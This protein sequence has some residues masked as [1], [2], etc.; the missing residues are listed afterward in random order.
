MPPVTV[1]LD[2]YALLYTVDA[3]RLPQQTEIDALADLTDTYLDDFFSIVFESSS[4]AQFEGSTTLEDETIVRFGQP[5]QTSYFTDLTFSGSSQIPSDGELNGLLSSAFRGDNLAT[6]LAEVQ[7]LPRSNFFATTSAV[8][9]SD[10]ADTRS[11]GGSDL[12]SGVPAV[13]IAAAAGA[14]AFFVAVVGLMLYRRRDQD[15]DEAGKFLDGDGHVTVAG[16]TYQ[17]GGSSL[18]SQSGVHRTQQFGDAESSV[19]PTEWGEEAAKGKIDEEQD[20]TSNLATSSD[21]IS[22]DDSS[23]DYSFAESGGGDDQRGGQEE[24]PHLDD[25]VL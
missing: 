13:G 25:V 21:E 19:S 6:Y 9:F 10:L 3:F 16:E 8:T 1:T 24:S 5:V 22:E 15:D 7:A 20:H 11:M 12:A 17:G 14:G 23:E 18:D 4:L 2:L